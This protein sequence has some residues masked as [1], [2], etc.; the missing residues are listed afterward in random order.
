MSTKWTS[1]ADRLR[2]RTLRIAFPV[3][4]TVALAVAIIA[5]AGRPELSAQGRGGAQATPRVVAP[6]DLTGYWVSVITEDWRFRMVTPLK[7]DYGIGSGTVPLTPEGRRIADTWDTSKDGSCLAYGAAGLMRMPM[8]VHITWESDHVLKIETDAGIQTRR[9]LFDKAQPPGARSL[10]GRSVAEWEFGPGTGPE[11]GGS[12]KVI[13]TN[14]TGGWLRKNG[15][16]YSENAVM[17]EYLDR[18]RGPTDDEWFTVNTIVEDPRY[19]ERP[20]ITSS[21]FKQEPDGSK[22][23]PYPCKATS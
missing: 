19:L 18:F 4:G 2:I 10:Q 11:R 15:V 1:R 12:L 14:M 16:P 20:F 23:R 22:W 13:T 5:V 17:T 6:I 21:H 3:A 8:R 7:G 9:L